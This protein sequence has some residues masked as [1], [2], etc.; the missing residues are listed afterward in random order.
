ME[1]L[2]QLE[3]MSLTKK[4]KWGWLTFERPE[5][6]NAFGTGATIRFERL[7]LALGEDPDIRI[8]VVRGT[9]R[10][11]CTGIDLKELAAGG[12]DMDYHHRWEHTLRRIELMEKIFIVGMHGYCL[13]GGLQLALACDIRVS[14]GDCRIGLPAVRE[15]LIPGLSTWRLPRYIGWGRAKKM[16]LG[17]E[18]ID[19]DRARRIGLVDHLVTG[20]RFFEQLDAVGARYVQACSVGTRLSK[21]LVNRAAD[22]DFEAFLEDYEALQKRAQYSLDALSAGRA[23]REGNKPEW[24]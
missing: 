3:G 18:N 22:H 20:E 12:I 2:L 21:L 7:V 14:T 1:N 10:A 23:H 17:G 24:Q 8:V 16:I 6:L 9:G 15:S 19:G 11:F 13:G 4:G 5:A